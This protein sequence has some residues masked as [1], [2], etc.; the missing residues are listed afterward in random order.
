M[1]DLECA[2]ARLS[3]HTLCLIRGDECLTSDER[4]ITPMMRLLSEGRDL[5]G[6]SA[7]DVVVGRAAAMLFVKAGIKAV[8]GKTMSEGA[9]AYLEEHGLF[10]RFEHL[11][12]AIINRQGTDVCPMEKAVSAITDAEEGY[13]ALLSRWG[14]LT[15]GEG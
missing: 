10:F 1:T 7:A 6:A 14:S 12:E 5:S 8:Y 15:S 2:I 3:G 11:T 13:N 4:G 9:K